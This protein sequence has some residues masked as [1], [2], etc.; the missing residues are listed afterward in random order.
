MAAR[1][2]IPLSDNHRRAITTTLTLLDQ[3]LCE[4]EHIARGRETRSVLYRQANDLSAA[5]RKR[6]LNE[7]A[8]ARET[9]REIKDTLSLETEP[10][11]LSSQVR[12][13]SS[14]MWESLIETQSRRLRGY[15]KVPQALAEYLDP[16]LDRLIDCS[17]NIGNIAQR[18]TDGTGRDANERP[19]DAC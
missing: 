3:R 12:A 4:F 15:G 18:R 17:V 13:G 2:H 8:T 1:R 11:S 16:T 6:L 14:S 10:E 7:I 9:L 5:Q 19:A